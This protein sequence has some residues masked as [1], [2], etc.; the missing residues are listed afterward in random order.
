MNYKSIYL[1]I[2]IMETKKTHCALNA[3]LEEMNLPIF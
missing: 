1:Q 3:M 2:I